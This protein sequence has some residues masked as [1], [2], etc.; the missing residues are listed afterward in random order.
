MKEWIKLLL[1]VAGFLIADTISP[2]T[3]PSSD[4]RDS[5]PS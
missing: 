3:I 5:K 1:I 2:G 4:S